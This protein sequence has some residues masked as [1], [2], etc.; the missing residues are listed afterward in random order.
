MICKN[1]KYYNYISQRVLSY[2]AMS[3]FDY[4]DEL[5]PPQRRC[6]DEEWIGSGDEDGGDSCVDTSNPANQF[7]YDDPSVKPVSS[8]IRDQVSV[9]A[10]AVKPPCRYGN[11]CRRPRGTCLF[12]HPDDADRA[13]RTAPAPAPAP[14]QRAVPAPTPAKKVIVCK[15]DE[16]CTNPKCWSSHPMRDLSIA[17]AEE[18]SRQ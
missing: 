15:F 12:S 17:L 1:I 8:S 4:A 3:Y 18:L 2:F 16:R 7:Y 9:G 13:V 11:G 14:A 5:N 6:D 10:P